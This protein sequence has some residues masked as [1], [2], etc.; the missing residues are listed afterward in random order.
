MGWRLTHG[1]VNSSVYVFRARMYNSAIT[2]AYFRAWAAESIF[3]TANRDYGSAL[4]SSPPGMF[5]IKLY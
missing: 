1:M 2:P 5:L 3:L 4:E